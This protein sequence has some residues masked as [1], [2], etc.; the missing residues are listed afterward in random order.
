MR[1]DACKSTAL[2]RKNREQTSMDIQLRANIRR[3]SWG[4]RGRPTITVSKCSIP[5]TISSS[6]RSFLPGTM[7]SSKFCKNSLS[8]IHS[9]STPSSPLTCHHLWPP[10]IYL[11]SSGPNQSIN[12]SAAALQVWMGIVI[13]TTAAHGG[14][15]TCVFVLERNEQREWG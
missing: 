12:R 9:A 2:E 7:S 3:E 4:C 13:G 14:A 6:H 10:T 8:V 11:R 5:N 1:L 15:G